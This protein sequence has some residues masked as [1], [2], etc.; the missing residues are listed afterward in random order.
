MLDFEDVTPRKRD[1]EENGEE[2]NENTAEEMEMN[3]SAE[4]DHPEEAAAEE[5][6]ETEPAPQPSVREY[7]YE[8]Q[9]K[10]APKKKKS[11]AKFVVGC[12]V[13]GIAGGASIGAGY[14]FVDN[15]MTGRTAVSGKPSGIQ[16]AS[17]GEI[18]SATDIIKAVKPSV[19]SVS[20]K[21]SGMASYWGAFSIPYESEGA[22]SGVIF[23]SDDDRVAIATN[24]H[25]VESANTIYVTFEGE[26]SVPAK[27]I[28]TRSES[29]LAVI[30]VS[31]KD[32]NDAGIEQVTTAVFGD[33]DALEVGSE[34]IAIGNAMGMGLS[35]T[36]GIISMKEQTINVDGNQLGVLQTSA[37]INSGNSGGAL[38]N[39]SGEVIG[40]N[41]AKYNSAMVE[42]MGYAIPSNYITPI[43]EE[44]LATGTQPKPY[45]GITG[46]NITEETAPMYKLPV[47][48]LVLEIVEGSPAE[49][50]GLEV[51][52]V[53][54]Q[55]N[56]QTV[57]DMD[58]LVKQVNEA[59]I[60]ST[61]D[62]Y[63]IRDGNTGVELKI[64]IE[65]KN[66]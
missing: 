35:A 55:F 29:D 57:M 59:K 4:E 31:W 7:H 46:T 33:S 53:I 22:G 26:I 20:T 3:H 49:K 15:L 14:S 5:V 11:W 34:V 64:K 1:M 62:M 24:N 25:V 56:G 60:G 40:I 66:S 38:V 51:G 27:V 50:A 10:K 2:Q 48:A 32:L 16:K 43:V 61:A 65:D 19:V 21:V 58:S 52:D 54:T 36:D 12:L 44:L 18:Y 42:G 30:T 37:A 28:G 6:S 13:I 63:V 39:A 23:Y 17:S 9:V 47:G 41:T 8:E 45:I